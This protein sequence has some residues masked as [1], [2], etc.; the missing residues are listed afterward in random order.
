MIIEV[1]V[2][3]FVL[4]SAVALYAHLKSKVPVEAKKIEAIASEGVIE[5]RGFCS[6]CGRK[7]AKFIKTADGKIVC[8]LHK[9]I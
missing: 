3:G 5:S 8:L 1:C 2:S 6:I 9:G 7:V 4:T